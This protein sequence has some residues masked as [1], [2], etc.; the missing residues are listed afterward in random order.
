MRD[1]PREPGTI[2]GYRSMKGRI[3]RLG[4]YG[5]ACA[6]WY[7]GTQIWVKNGNGTRAERN[8]RP[9]EPVE[10]RTPEPPGGPMAKTTRA[11]RAARIRAREGLP[12]DE[13]DCELCDRGDD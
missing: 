4:D 7:G 9:W 11:R 5:V 2:Y 8:A 3:V 1:L 6:L 10:P 12:E 13:C